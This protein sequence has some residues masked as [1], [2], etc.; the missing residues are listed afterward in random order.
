[1]LHG[2]EHMG[3]SLRGVLKMS[4]LKKYM[5][6]EQEACGLLDNILM[7]PMSA[8]VCFDTA[9]FEHRYASLVGVSVNQKLTVAE[10]IG[11]AW[12]SNECKFIRLK[13]LRSGFIWY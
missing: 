4:N 12:K 7:C 8:G 13:S 1:M 5:K 2:Y 3:A 11:T 10:N 6:M 9:H